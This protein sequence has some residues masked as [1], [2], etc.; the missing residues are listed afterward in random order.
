MTTVVIVIIALLSFCFCAISLAVL[1]LIYAKYK[2]A[3]KMKQHFGDQI[4]KEIPLQS[5]T[6]ISSP[7]H[8][9]N[10]LAS[11]ISDKVSTVST[12]NSIQTGDEIKSTISD[13]D[14]T[15]NAMDGIKE[16][17]QMTQESYKYFMGMLHHNQLSLNPNQLSGNQ[18]IVHLRLAH[19]GQPV[20]GQQ[21]PINT[22]MASN[23]YPIHP[24]MNNL[25]NQQYFNQCPPPPP[26]Q[27]MAYNPNDVNMHNMPIQPPFNNQLNLIQ[28]IS[29]MKISEMKL[30]E[31]AQ[32]IQSDDLCD[33]PP[34]NK[35]DDELSEYSEATVTSN[36]H[37]D[38]EKEEED[39]NGELS[40]CT[41]SESMG[42]ETKQNE[43][44]TNDN[45]LTEDFEECAD[46]E[47]IG[48][49]LDD[50]ENSKHSS[51]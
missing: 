49:H 29:E 8:N 46:S 3:E 19:Q 1:W 51:Y 11:P 25:N 22:N 44:K 27:L 13:I 32:N 2:R 15:Q 45:P 47:W 37:N 48:S 7:N 17:A 4:P 24:V 16:T 31:S 39:D 30:N 40:D 42:D 23:H 35:H 38:D 5:V 9:S 20:Q 28:Q 33:N 43:N 21:Y 36:G 14:N 34:E 6:S 50:E 18:Q 10:Y 41:S 12:L 26:Q